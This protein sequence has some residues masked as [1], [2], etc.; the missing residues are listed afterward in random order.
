MGGMTESLMGLQ[1]ATQ[2]L[3]TEYTLKHKSGK[4]LGSNYKVFCLRVTT[5]LD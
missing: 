3:E 2:E 1:Q 5:Y 4:S